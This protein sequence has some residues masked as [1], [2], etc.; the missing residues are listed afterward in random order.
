MHSDPIELTFE[1]TPRARFDIINVRRHAAAL[2]GSAL[3]A[4]PQ[5]LYYSAHT[6]AGYLE[7]G[8]ARRL[9]RSGATVDP[10]VA[11][12]RQLF[13]EGAPYEHDQLARRNDLTSAQRA[14]ER[15]RRDA[16]RA[17]CRRS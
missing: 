10:Y 8:L 17:F 3:D 7:Q 6:T 11:V 13:P 14:V 1:L 5:C 12:F 16:Q 2:H 4:F 15:R 9:T